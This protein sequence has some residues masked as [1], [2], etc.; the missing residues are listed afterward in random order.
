MR[1]I[2][3]K[4]KKKSINTYEDFSFKKT[5]PH[6][7]PLVEF[8]DFELRKVVFFFLHLRSKAK[9]WRKIIPFLPTL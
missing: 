3:Q 6:S 7:P 8:G 5:P 2:F 9:V 1:N 4:K